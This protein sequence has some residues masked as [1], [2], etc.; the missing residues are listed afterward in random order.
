MRL[1]KGRETGKLLFRNANLSARGR[2]CGC[3]LSGLQ[4]ADDVDVDRC[5]HLLVVPQL[6]QSGVHLIVGVKTAEHACVPL[7]RVGLALGGLHH[8]H[9]VL[10]DEHDLVALF[11]AQPLPHLLQDG[12]LTF[13]GAGGSCAHLWYSSLN[14]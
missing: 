13:L 3:R 1:T 12:D 11:E 7:E 8:R 5:E 9:P 6:T 4:C 14:T 2:R 10:G